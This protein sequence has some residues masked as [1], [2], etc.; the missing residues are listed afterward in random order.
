MKKIFF[1]LLLPLSVWAQKPN[2]VI[3]KSPIQ[4]VKLFL[5]AGEMYHHS[6]VKVKKGRNKLI[7]AGISA[8]ANPQSI[9]FKGN[10][11]HHL[12]SFSTEMDFLAAEQYNPRIVV[13]KDSLNV[14]DQQWQMNQDVLGS[15]QAELSVLNS[16]RDLKGA[17]QNI[18]VE[19][20]REAADFYRKRTL[21]VNKEMTKVN[22]EKRRLEDLQDRIRFQLSEL[23]FNE[24]LRS[25]QVIVLIDVDQAGEFSCDLSY[26]V[27]DCGWNATYDLTAQDLN[28]KIGLKYKAKVYNSTGNDW[29]DVDLILS[30][31]NPDLS[32]SSP[33]LTPWYLSPAELM[34]IQKSGYVQAKAQQIDY[35]SSAVSSINSANQRVYDNYLSEDHMNGKGRNVN[36]ESSKQKWDQLSREKKTV[37]IEEIEISELTAEFIIPNKFS[38]PTD[39]K[40]YVVEV[41]DLFLDATFSHITI[42]KLDH[43]S[44]LMANIVG[45]QEL[46]LMPGPT[47]V[48]FAGKYVGISDIDVRQ[49]GDTLALSFG[50][51]TKVEVQRKLKSEMSSK[52]IV[53]SSI[54]ESFT[55]E[56]LIQNN[57]D[58][59]IKMTVYDQIP[60]SQN[61]DITISSESYKGGTKDEVTGEVTWEISLAPDEVKTLQLSYMVKHPKDMN[62]HLQRV[63]K[64]KHPRYL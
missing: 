41:K 31:A 46:D 63:R 3:I 40:P 26:L 7:F 30:T 20:I 2:E 22:R 35:R 34:R 13:L 11:P 52:K 21:E 12:I 60:V 6:V 58:V 16:N 39:A 27:S 43:A 51:D 28:Q 44:F 25:N 4:K 33:E 5:T 8:Y 53:G 36:N 54:R 29:T 10:T 24:N 17:N 38:C 9:Q 47:N 57:H 1:A 42:P 61:S 64:A 55:Y 59:G 49:V 15:F 48:Y 45:W 18:N 62:V 56:I 50:R 32:A 19:Q 37:V 23:N 14:I